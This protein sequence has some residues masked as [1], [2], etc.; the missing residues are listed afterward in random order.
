MRS[1][2]YSSPDNNTI[3]VADDETGE[4]LFVPVAPGNR[5]YDEIVANNI[6]VGAFTPPPL[7]LDDYRQSIEAHVDGVAQSRDYSSAVSLASY[8]SSSNPLW[9]A[10]ADVFVVWRDD[11]WAYALTEL[12]KVLNAERPQPTLQEMIDELP[13]IVW[14]EAA[15]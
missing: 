7:G 10:E 3:I 9:K 5:D 6:E 8:T 15:E 1:Y 12:P 13:V 4:M 11:V 2:T 14:P